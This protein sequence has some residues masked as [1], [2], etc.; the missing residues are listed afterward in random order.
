M[1]YAK[2]GPNPHIRTQNRIT[3]RANYE[4]GRLRYSC[5][6]PSCVSNKNASS[7]HGSGVSLNHE[8]RTFFY[9]LFYLIGTESYSLKFSTSS[10][11]S[12]FE[13]RMSH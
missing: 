11:L 10:V 3:V 2:L 12:C 7:S 5:Y 9:S 6:F 1:Q 4:Y 13:K 8:A